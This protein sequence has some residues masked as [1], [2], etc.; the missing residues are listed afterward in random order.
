MSYFGVD[1]GRGRALLPTCYTVL[2]RNASSHCLLNWQF[3][4]SNDQTAW[5]VL[6]KRMYFTG[7]AEVDQQFEECADRMK[8]S[9]GTT[10]CGIDTGIYQSDHGFEGYRFFRI[11]QIGLNSSGGHTLALSGLELYGRITRG[12]WV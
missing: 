11:V 12:K 8:K 1:L 9:G 2:N 10:T 4:G 3:E 5:T 7:D 6:D